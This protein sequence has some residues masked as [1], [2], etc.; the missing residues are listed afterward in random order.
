MDNTLINKV[1]QEFTNK[2][3]IIMGENLIQCRMYGSCARGDY[4][5]YSDIDIILLTKCNRTESEEYT[6]ALLDIVTDLALKYMVVINTLCV[7][8]SEYEDKKTWYDLFINIENEG[9]IIY[10]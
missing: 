8:F 9:R 2:I 1:I 6:E 10:G 7:P 5:D 4:D 3:H